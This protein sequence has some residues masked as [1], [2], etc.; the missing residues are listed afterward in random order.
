[1]LVLAIDPGETTGLVLLNYFI[2]SI[3][4]LVGWKEWILKQGVEEYACSLK[5]LLC[6]YRSELGAVVIEDYRIYA[7]KADLHI[8]NRL[9]TAELIGATH[10]ICATTPKFLTVVTYPASK[11]GRWPDARL[12]HWFPN[13]GVV[14]TH[15]IDALKLGLAYIEKELKWIP[16]WESKWIPS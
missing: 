14:G 3:P 16:I 10:A 15:A 13:P 2:G 5:D 1:M 7:G 8:G 9:F 11:K 4:L 6:D 12:S